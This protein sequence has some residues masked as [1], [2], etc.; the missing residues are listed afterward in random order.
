MRMVDAGAC[1]ALEVVVHEIPKSHWGV[2]R[3]PAGEPAWAQGAGVRGSAA[4]AE[5]I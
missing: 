4:G 3:P 1:R 2:G 5:Q